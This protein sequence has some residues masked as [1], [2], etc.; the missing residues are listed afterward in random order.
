MLPL[1]IVLGIAGAVIL[2]LYVVAP[3]IVFFMH[4]QSPA[5]EVLPHDPGPYP[6]PAD[7]FF[8]ELG[9]RLADLGFGETQRW[10]FRGFA[11]NVA[12]EFCTMADRRRRVLAVG[13]VMHVRRGNVFRPHS[14]FLELVS[15]EGKTRTLNTSNSTTPLLVTDMGERRIVLLPSLQDPSALLNAH[16]KLV[17]RDRLATSAQEPPSRAEIP[18]RVREAI[19]ASHAWQV[20]IG[21]LSPLPSGSFRLTL[22]GAFLFTWTALPPGKQWLKRR[23]AARE[24]L[25]LK[26]LGIVS[27]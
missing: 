19:A 20:S 7:E 5:P 12:A 8:N 25:L 15:S 11:P 1:L 3:L 18:G 10:S 6:T 27:A 17:S 24:A 16:Q 22:K 2:L 4:R 23:C 14:T 9:P 26:D 13:Y 21:L